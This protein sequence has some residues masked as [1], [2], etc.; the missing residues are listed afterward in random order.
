MVFNMLFMMA[1][2][3]GFEATSR[4]GHR[5]SRPH[6]RHG[7][8]ANI[9][10]YER[11]R[12]ELRLGR[13]RARPSTWGST[14]LRAVLDGHVSNAIAGVVL[15][16]YGSA[17]PRFAVTLIVGII[18]NLITS[19]AMSRWMFDLMVARASHRPPASASRNQPM[20]KFFE[21]IKPTR[22]TSSWEAAL[23]PRHLGHPHL[24]QPGDA[25]INHFWRGSALNYSVDMRGG[26]EIRVEFSKAVDVGAIRGSLD[27]GGFKN[28]EGG[29]VHRHGAPAL[30]L[31]RLHTI[32]PSPRPRP[33]T[34]TPR[35][36]RSSAQE[37]VRLREG[38]TRPT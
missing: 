2:L 4:S 33:R 1:I 26:T 18:T 29:E 11:I 16:Q 30:Y 7:G 25:P 28:A 36:R 32:S 37:P 34:P 27:K 19:V 21:V 35:S 5:G 6:H 14:R 8:D 20:P 23:L 10:F 15:Y 9:I 3:A 24:H 22:A 12:E 13:R 17:H 38:A 31:L